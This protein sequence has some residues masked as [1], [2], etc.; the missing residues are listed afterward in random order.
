MALTLF[1]DDI[2]GLCSPPW[3][4]LNSR[5]WRYKC[6]GSGPHICT[7]QKSKGRGKKSLSEVFPKEKKIVKQQNLSPCISAWIEPW[8]DHLQVGSVPMLLDPR[9]GDGPGFLFLE[10]VGEW[11]KTETVLGRRKSNILVTY[12]QATLNLCLKTFLITI[13]FSLIT[14]LAGLSQNNYF[15]C[16]MASAGGGGCLR[17]VKGP[18]GI[19]LYLHV[20]SVWSPWCGSFP[21]TETLT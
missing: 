6:T 2:L 18:L 5:W 8:N 10:L 7:W 15:L 17:I 1:L 13:L 11:N 21:V 19:S 16:H 3:R 9:A 14:I 20:V 12:E 4:R